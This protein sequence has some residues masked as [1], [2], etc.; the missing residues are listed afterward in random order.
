MIWLTT[1]FMDDFIAVYSR[2]KTKFLRYNNE[3]VNPNII[4]ISLYG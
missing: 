4:T 1:S 3:R 2:A